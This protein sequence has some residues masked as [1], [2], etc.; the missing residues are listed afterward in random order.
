M[1]ILQERLSLIFIFL[2]FFSGNAF[3]LL[4]IFIVKI[5]LIPFNFWLNKIINQLKWFDILVFFRFLKIIPLWIIMI[6]IRSIKVFILLLLGLLLRSTL[7]LGIFSIKFL[8]VFSSSIH[9]Y[10]ILFFCL[11]NINYSLIYIFFYFVCLFMFLNSFFIFNKKENQFSFLLLFFLMRL[12]PFPIFI[13]KWRFLSFLLKRN[14]LLFI[15]I[16][17]FLLLRIIRY[18]RVASWIINVYNVFKIKF[19]LKK[20]ILFLFLFFTFFY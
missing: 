19:F 10:I 5:A 12:P 20:F 3:I 8:F 13:I 14:M 17:F 4:L 6:F 11:R 2:I 1:F 16:V 18:F 9:S 15:I 7:I